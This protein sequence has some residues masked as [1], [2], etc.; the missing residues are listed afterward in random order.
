MAIEF[1]P[2]RA[3]EMFVHS[4]DPSV[5]LSEGAAKKYALE[6]KD[7]GCLILEQDAEISGSPTRFEIRPLATPEV[8][9]FQKLVEQG[10]EQ[11]AMEKSVRGGLVSIDGEKFNPEKTT[12]V[13][14]VE[15]A[16]ALA[17]IDLSLGKLSGN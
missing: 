8:L 15:T 17:I 10:H 12:L 5:K 9:K 7:G 3:L 13:Y 2:D 6:E 4:S 16:V 14:F 11:Q 1:T